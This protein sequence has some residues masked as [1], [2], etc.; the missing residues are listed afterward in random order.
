MS[1]PRRVRRYVIFDAFASGGMASVHLGKLLSQIGVG[2][3]VAVKC[4]HPSREQDPSVVSM[5]LDEATLTLRLQHTNVV[6]TLDVLSQDGELLIVMEYVHGPSLRFLLSQAEAVVQRLP[7]PVVARIL[8]S[9]LEGL[10]A[11]HEMHSI[12]GQPLSIVHR[13][14]SPQNILV[15]ADGVTRVLDFGVAKAAGRIQS[16]EAGQVKGK[17]AY[18]APEQLTYAH[19]VDRRADIYAAG[20]VLWE[21][22][23]G[24]RF[25]EE[26]DEFGQIVGRKLFCSSIPATNNCTESVPALEAI[27][28]NALHPNPNERFATAREMALAIE[29]A[30]DLASE[31]AV[32][33]CV[34][35]YADAFLKE[36]EQL[37]DAVERASSPSVVASS[38][39]PP[40]PAEPGE[41]HSRTEDPADGLPRLHS[42]VADDSS[43]RSLRAFAP[44][45][46]SRE[47]PERR[48]LHVVLGAA[49]VAT[50]T[51]AVIL[52]VYG[53]R[54][55]SRATSYVVAGDAPSIGVATQ[56]ASSTPH[57]SAPDDPTRSQ[58]AP[59]QA[60][61]GSADHT[62]LAPSPDVEPK[63]AKQAAVGEASRA[64]R[65]IPS[66]TAKKPSRT[67]SPK[68]GCN[69][70]YFVDERGVKVPK[71]HCI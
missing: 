41:R 61:S 44:G 66:T 48:R 33:A 26:G 55:R 30:V 12:T 1:V 28:L 42:T 64:S 31:R 53:A 2:R 4:L 57:A 17:I 58:S 9:T 40:P 3:I 27:V 11:A 54:R 35:Q 45:E 34:K 29:Q 51:I 65:A 10:H 14:V 68:S 22:L 16:T 71:A 59:E 43:E 25:H 5:L 67:P 18:M 60:L 63:R 24:R 50:L 56:Q 21:G 19:P 38:I 62:F 47:K 52:G 23:S 15:G 70:P 39:P 49:I 13:D 37:I 6:P 36:R 7:V 46:T 8:V 69:P 20:I 32:A